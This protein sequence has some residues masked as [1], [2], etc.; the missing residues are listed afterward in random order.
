MTS[1]TLRGKLIEF[2]GARYLGNKAQF[3]M[4]VSLEKRSP[5]KAPVAERY[6]CCSFYVSDQ[7]AAGFRAGQPIRITIEQ[8]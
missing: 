1:V 3:M 4:Q 2:L 8:D 7:S 5:D 6:Y